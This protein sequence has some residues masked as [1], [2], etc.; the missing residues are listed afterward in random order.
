MTQVQRRNTVIGIVLLSSLIFALQ[1][2]LKNSVYEIDEAEGSFSVYYYAV[3]PPLI[4]GLSA[5]AGLWLTGLR[6][7]ERSV[8]EWLPTIAV[9]SL[10]PL[11]AK[12]PVLGGRY[13]EGSRMVSFLTYAL[14]GVSLFD[15]VEAAMQRRFLGFRPLD[16]LVPALC[17][18]LTALAPFCLEAFADFRLAQ[19]FSANPRDGLSPQQLYLFLAGLHALCLVT[20]LALLPF[21]RPAT[22]AARWAAVAIGAVYIALYAVMYF[23]PDLP[24]L[25]WFSQ[26]FDSPEYLCLPA[27]L[28]C[29]GLIPVRKA[30]K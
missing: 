10:I 3:L 23:L 30:K 11:L 27:G 28:L 19:T 12:V 6:G 16:A 20:G 5:A 9:A 2:L 25:P 8:L 4:L 24:R 22:R 14:L 17:A 1:F 29:T 13:E 7:K 15:A 21:A 18:A 26:C